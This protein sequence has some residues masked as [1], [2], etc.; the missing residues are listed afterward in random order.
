MSL[1]DILPNL[2]TDMNSQKLAFL[3]LKYV[4]SLSITELQNV[5]GNTVAG[6]CVESS[7]FARI[8]IMFCEVIRVLDLCKWELGIK[9]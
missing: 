9:C 6:G 8:K 3:F 5:S 7:T 1:G 4:L 2:V